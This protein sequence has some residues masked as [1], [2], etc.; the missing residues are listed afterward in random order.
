MVLC[1][2]DATRKARLP[3]HACCVL[4]NQKGGIMDFSALVTSL[5]NTLG[6]HVPNILGALG[7]LVV[8]WL[9]AVAARAGSVRLLSLLQVDQRIR[10]STGQALGV[11][12]VIAVG[13][14]WLIMLVT[15]LGMLNALDLALV[16]NPFQVLANQIFGYLPRLLGGTALMLIA[17]LAA[18]VLRA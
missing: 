7:I 5:Q 18:S 8:G 15:L 16:S 14:F 10:E 1:F 9:I 17:W 11:E 6:A 2:R 12:T 3:L 13:V 4:I